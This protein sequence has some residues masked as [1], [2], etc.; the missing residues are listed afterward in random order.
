MDESSLISINPPTEHHRRHPTRTSPFRQFPITLGG[1]SE[2]SLNNTVI[3]DGLTSFSRPIRPNGRI[4]NA[5]FTRSEK[6]R[7]T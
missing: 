1:K 6:K 5:L 3:I 4:A 2:L 7:R